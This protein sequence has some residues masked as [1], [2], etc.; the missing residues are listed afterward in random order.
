LVRRLIR[1]SALLLFAA[2]FAT[3]LVQNIR[4]KRDMAGFV[5]GRRLMPRGNALRVDDSLRRFVI[6]DR[7]G[8]PVDQRSILSGHPTTI[9]HFFA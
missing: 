2:S 6:L 7:A 3:L 9:V 1:L 8:S 5:S 4:L